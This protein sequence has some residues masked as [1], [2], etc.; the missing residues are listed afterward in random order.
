M[1][2]KQLLALALVALAATHSYSAQVCFRQKKAGSVLRHNFVS[3]W[4][5]DA[6]APD[7]VTRVTFHIENPF[8]YELT[9]ITTDGAS[10][11]VG[12]PGTGNTEGSYY[13]LRLTNATFFNSPCGQRPCCVRVYCMPQN[14]GNCTGVEFR[15]HYYN[16]LP[17][18]TPTALPAASAMLRGR[19]EA[20]EGEGGEQDADTW[21]F[22]EEVTA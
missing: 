9:V 20:V 11:C 4:R 6:E 3:T 5:C 13:A 12:N 7:T 22:T 19:D 8:G 1:A 14:P 17:D 16:D 10:N 2:V 15:G 18:P 21:A